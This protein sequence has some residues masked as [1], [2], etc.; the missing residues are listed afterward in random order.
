[1]VEVETTGEKEEM[2]GL[3]Y[4]VV[5]AVNNSLAT[6]VGEIISNVNNSITIYIEHVNNRKI[7]GRAE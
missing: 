1:M 7:K 4:D 3:R 2:S 5:S 6:V